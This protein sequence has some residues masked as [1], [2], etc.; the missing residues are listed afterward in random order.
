MDI[1]VNLFVDIYMYIYV[2]VYCNFEIILELESILYVE[3]L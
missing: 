3:V 1:Y 2:L